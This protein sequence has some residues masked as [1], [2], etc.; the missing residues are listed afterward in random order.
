MSCQWQVMEEG[1]SEAR[2][3][4]STKIGTFRE[5][6]DKLSMIPHCPVPP[7]IIDIAKH[8]TGNY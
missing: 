5:H 1:E 8:E 7:T 6:F 4:I 2:S 3:Q